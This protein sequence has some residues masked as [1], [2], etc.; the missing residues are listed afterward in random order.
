MNRRILII[1]NEENIRRVTRLTLQAA[2]YEVAEAGDG[3]L[4]L[5]A[6][7]DGSTWDAVLLDQ[8]MPGMDGLETLRRINERDASARVIMATAYASIE[9]AVDAMKLGATDF[10]RKPMTPEILRNAVA[11]ALAKQPRAREEISAPKTDAT[12][13]P[14]VQIITMNG[15][16]IL[17]SQNAR[18]DPNERRF[19][20]KS[21]TG[22][23]HEV[24][25]QIDDEAVGYVERMIR[26]R[27]PAE[28][29]FWTGQAQRI[30]SDYLWQ[31]GKIPPTRK[32][33]I[34]EIDRDDLPMAAHWQS[35]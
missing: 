4:G 18:P 31:E 3:E 12:A 17:D 35:N 20:V 5:D 24:L 14:L 21:P 27:L 16:T 15:F 25:V 9:L 34:Q 7:G 22:S 23:E 10:V 30:L 33:T 6:F 2:G 11:A 28:N 26:R 19:L 1:D 13:K 8:R 32:L 29:S